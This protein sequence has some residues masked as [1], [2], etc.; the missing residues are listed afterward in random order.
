MRRTEFRGKSVESGEWVYGDLF[1]RTGFSIFS[2]YYISTSDEGRLTV[3]EVDPDTVGEYTGRDKGST[4]IYEGD[5]TQY[6]VVEYRAD[7]NWDSGGSVHPGF[8]FSGAYENGETGSLSY[9]SGFDDCEIIGNI[10]DN[11]EMVK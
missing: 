8:Y 9:H 6:G 7:L 11:P 1:G 10:H 3:V 4:R 2:K 5:I